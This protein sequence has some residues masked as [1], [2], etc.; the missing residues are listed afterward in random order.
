V[1]GRRGALRELHVDLNQSGDFLWVVGELNA[2][3]ARYCKQINLDLADGQIHEINLDAEDFLARAAKAIGEGFLITV[4]YGAERDELLRAPQRFAGTLRA[5][6]RHQ[7]LDDAIADP[8]GQDLTT[9]IDWTQIRDLGTAH[10]F[11]ERGFERLDRFLINEG[12][13][14]QLATLTT[15]QSSAAEIVRLQLGA[16]EMIRP[17]G[18]D[19]SFQV[20]IQSKTA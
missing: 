3:V 1:I 18:L 11:A 9:T 12:L 20:L 5:F 8:G 14:E 2:E 19:A 10:G 16:R 7:L 13:L 6:S 17:D 15:G 4:D